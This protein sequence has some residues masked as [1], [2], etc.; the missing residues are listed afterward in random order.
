MFPNP[1]P[2]S[3]RAPCAVVLSAILLIAC[4]GEDGPTFEIPAGERLQSIQLELDADGTPHILAQVGMYY[5][6]TDE[7]PVW[8]SRYNLSNI[9]SVVF[10]R[11]A[12][13]WKR[14]GFRNLQDNQSARSALARNAGGR[15]QP[16]IADNGEFNL[17]TRD[18]SGW[19]LKASKP[20]NLEGNWEMFSHSYLQGRGGPAMVMVGDHDW[21]YIVREY[22][23]NTTQLRGHDGSRITLD[24]GWEFNPLDIHY[25]KGFTMLIGKVWPQS[26]PVFEGSTMN[27]IPLPYITT[28]SWNGEDKNPEIRKRILNRNF[29]SVHF[30]K[31]G[32]EDRLYGITLPDTVEEYVLNGED[33]VFRKRLT[34]PKA[35][36]DTGFIAEYRNPVNIAVDPAGCIHQIETRPMDSDFNP[37]NP[38]Y[39]VTP[40]AYF[41]WSSCRPGA[42]T[43]ALPSP[44][45]DT[46]AFSRELSEFRY[47]ADGTAMVALAVRIVGK[48][49][50]NREDKPFASW[51]YL[52][53]LSGTRWEWEKVAEYK[54]LEGN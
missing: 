34:L 9:Q 39:P 11:Q 25:G 32:D 21:R 12:G 18:G 26:F 51:L 15:I 19:V 45:P 40:S 24:S 54:G 36:F 47:A 33:L 7:L 27:A 52:G 49:Q 16:L 41:H 10:S 2:K 13:E 35:S 1:L 30:A 28:L 4:T 23:H 5:S 20:M 8:Q 37:N 46:A 29:G 6:T 48:D 14:H 43:L 38:Y 44:A 42:D 50:Y 22:A 31:V 53:R 3:G 17:Y